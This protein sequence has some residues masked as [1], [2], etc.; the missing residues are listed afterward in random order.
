M[1]EVTQ[2]LMS[3]ETYDWVGLTVDA[4]RTASFWFLQTCQPLWVL[5]Q[6]S[7]LPALGFR[8]VLHITGAWTG[9]STPVDAGSTMV[10]T[11]SRTQLSITH[12]RCLSSL[13]VPILTTYHWRELPQVS[14]LSQQTHVCHDITHFLSQQKYACHNKTFVSTKLCLSRQNVF[15]AIKVLSPQIFLSQQAYFC[16]NKRC[17]LSRQTCVT[18]V[19]TKFMFVAT[20]ICHSRTFVATNTCCRD[21]NDTCGSSCQWY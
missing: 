8:W 13:Q 19:A 20:N 3:S 21:E 17:V 7:S 18:F 6:R 16:R 15:V 9:V 2:L 4:Y 10:S 5:A 1:P 11:C 14:F 12:Y